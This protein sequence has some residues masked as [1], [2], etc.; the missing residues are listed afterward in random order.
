MSTR[1]VRG[2]EV[3]RSAEAGVVRIL[4][5]GDSIIWAD[6]LPEDETFVAQTEEHLR[7][8]GRRV[9]VL[10][11]GMGDIGI[12]EEVAILTERGVKAGP[13]IVVLNFYLNDSRPPWGFSAEL[14]GK[15]WWRTHSALV[16]E[17]YS[18]FLLWGWLRDQGVDRFAWVPVWRRYDWM[19]DRQAFLQ[20]ATL[21]RYDWGAAWE[22]DSW[23]VIERGFD[24][25]VR[26]AQSNSFRLAVVVH[27]VYFQVHAPY[28]EDGR[29]RRVAALAAQAGAPVLDLLPLHRALSDRQVF[30]DWCHPVAD[31]NARMGEWLADFLVREGLAGP[32]G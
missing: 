2:P 16:D 7:S 18:R 13:A 6:Y 11:G 29:Q 8:T 23:V 3:T 30:Y 27:P 9:E 20:L 22:D 28:L 15:G 12:R 21:A 25:L 10:N 31:V 19:H 1:W 17:F 26:L 32:G 24:E 5:L 14:G 4:A